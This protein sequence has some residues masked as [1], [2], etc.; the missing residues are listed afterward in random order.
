MVGRKSKAQKQSQARITLI[1][2]LCKIQALDPV[3]GGRWQDGMVRYYSERLGE[4]LLVQAGLSE[5]PRELVIE[6]SEYVRYAL[7][8]DGLEGL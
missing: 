7:A 2:T 6:V 1:Q 8:T 5:P 3:L 4:L